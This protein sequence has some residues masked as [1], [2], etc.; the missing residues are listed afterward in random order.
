MG[1]AR[2]DVGCRASQP[3]CAPDDPKLIFVEVFPSSI[4]TE[5]ALGFGCF[6]QT[7]VTQHQR[8]T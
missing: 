5:S 3:A 2:L 7:P 4:R 6:R 1:A 8:K